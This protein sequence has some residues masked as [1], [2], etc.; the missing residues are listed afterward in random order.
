MNGFH[1]SEHF[2][3]LKLILE[4]SHSLKE[5]Y[6]K[7]KSNSIKN[8]DNFKLYL[9]NLEKLEYVKL[10]LHYNEFRKKDINKITKNLDLHKKVKLEIKNKY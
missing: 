9:N 2:S 1:S 7:L 3:F 5:L 8:T 6:L 10:N 4:N